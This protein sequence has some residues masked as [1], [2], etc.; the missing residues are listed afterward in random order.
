MRAKVTDFHGQVQG[1]A[2]GLAGTG[3]SRRPYGHT[4]LLYAPAMG[5]QTTTKLDVTEAMIPR[6]TCL[7]VADLL[8]SLS[9]DDVA[10]LGDWSKSGLQHHFPSKAHIAE[11]LLEG[12]LDALQ[13]DSDYS[14]VQRALQGLADGTCDLEQL[15]HELGLMI[16]V[17]A[18]DDGRPDPKLEAGQVATWLLAIG[19]QD[20]T[21]YGAATGRWARTTLAAYGGQVRETYAS[22]LALMVERSGRS[23][24]GPTSAEDL[25]AATT[26]LVEGFL[27]LRRGRAEDHDSGSLQQSLVAPLPGVLPR[28]RHEWAR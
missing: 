12:A 6:L 15:S 7:T 19:V 8:A 16:Q 28:R 24:K 17:L 5:K 18:P 11:S 13:V 21:E 4:G 2:N 20:A 14:G 22:M 25:V 1:R 9:Y 3:V 27:L 23:W 26:A 10:R